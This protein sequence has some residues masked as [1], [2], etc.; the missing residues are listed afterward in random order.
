[1]EMKWRENSNECFYAWILR[2]YAPLLLKNVLRIANR[3]FKEK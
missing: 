2:E 3:T 1:M